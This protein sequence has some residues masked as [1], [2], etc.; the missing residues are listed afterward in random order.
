MNATRARVAGRGGDGGGGVVGA[1]VLAR[2]PA[3]AARAQRMPAAGAGAARAHGTAARGTRRAA[4]RRRARH[5]HLGSVLSLAPI[6][7]PAL[8]LSVLSF[9]LFDNIMCDYIKSKV[10]DVINL[11]LLN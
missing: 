2:G 8:D 10:Y 5:S 6:P 4:R 11:S 7:I 9:F 1:A 3:A